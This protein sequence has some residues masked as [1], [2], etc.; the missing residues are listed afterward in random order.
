MRRLAWTGI[1]ALA[2]ALGPRAARAGD[3]DGPDPRTGAGTSYSPP[4]DPPWLGI[5]YSMTTGTVG[6]LVTNVFEDSPAIAAGL[7]V[8]DEI[9]EVDGMET[10]PYMGDLSAVIAGHSV[11][12]QMVVRVLRDG[13][14]VT[15]RPVLANRVSEAELLHMQLV[16]RPPP[17]FALVQPDDPEG[18]PIDDS[19]F[20]GRVGILAWFHTSC[21]GCAALV[22]KIQPWVDTHRG[23][24][25]VVGL[26]GLEGQTQDQAVTTAKAVVGASP[27]LLPVGIDIDAYLHY[28]FVSNTGDKAIF[29]VVDRSGIIQMAT[30]I[31]AD[32]DDSALDDVF[33]AAERALKQRKPRR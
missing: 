21:V 25:G 27:I 9:I 31:P 19:I 30:V 6:L 15:L 7:R 26:G 16:G 4:V 8:G 11:G 3:D 20:A 32:A 22:N 17:S 2:I 24:V 5:A 12:D 14:G 29:V 10:P 28:G 1:A 23:A 13:R 18:D 33:A